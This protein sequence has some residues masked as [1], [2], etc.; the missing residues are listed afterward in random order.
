[1]VKVQR[2]NSPEPDVTNRRAQ[3]IC[4][5]LLFFL[6][7]ASL[8]CLVLDHQEIVPRLANDF[9]R[10]LAGHGAYAVPLLF[11]FAG[12]M[13]LIG[14]ERLAVSHSTVGTLLLFLVFV[15]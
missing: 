5:L 14:Y 13:F 12:A 10:L 1:M 4:G 6:G 8:L 2:A 3:D 11:M 7:A 15:T 9:L